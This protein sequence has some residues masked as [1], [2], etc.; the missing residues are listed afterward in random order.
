MTKWLIIKDLSRGLMTKLQ[1]FKSEW[2]CVG[3]WIVYRFNTEMW[4]YRDIRSSI[5]FLVPCQGK[6]IKISTKRY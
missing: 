1:V 6:R 5:L 2:I 3:L 4:R